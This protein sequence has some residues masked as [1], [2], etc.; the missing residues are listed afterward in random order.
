MP[1]LLKPVFHSPWA[2]LR[3]LSSQA[4][5]TEAQAEPV[6]RNKRGHHSEK[7]A[8]HSKEQ[9]PLAATLET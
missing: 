7:P 5:V 8:H 2:E 3:L 4:A 9:F 1:Q 6:L